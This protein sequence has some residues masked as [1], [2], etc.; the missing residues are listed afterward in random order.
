[1]GLF[2]IKNE[3]FEDKSV[4][5]ETYV[6]D[7]LP[8]REE[9]MY[10]YRF[11]LEDI[12]TG[13]EPNNILVYGETGVGKTVATRRILDA[14]SDAVEDQDDVSFE[15][16]WVNCKDKTSYQATV[17]TVNEL[18]DFEDRIKGTGYSRSDVLNMLWRE[19][20]ALEA[21]H[22]MI[23]L[24]EVDS[25]G[26]DDSLLYQIPRAKA[27]GHVDTMIGVI[28]IS[29]NF[30][31]RENIS[32][33]ASSTLKED[34]I[35]FSTYDAPQLQEILLQRSELAFKDGVLDEGIVEYVAAIVAQDTGSARDAIEILRLAGRLA[36]KHEDATVT[37]DHVREASEQLERVIVEKELYSLPT[38]YHVLL[39]SIALLEKKG[40]LPAR[41]KAVYNVYE[42]V[43]N[44][45]QISPKAQRTIHDKLSQLALKGFLSITEKNK[46]ESGGKYWEYDLEIN[47]D[48]VNEVLD[49]VDRLSDIREETTLSQ[50]S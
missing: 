36:R 44:D 28:G 41:R 14:L 26:T 4:L 40:K 17:D 48:T 45:I 19:I 24:D 33:R 12:K 20:D 39:Q 8:G 2:D 5:R 23:V 6:P 31:F 34:E 43:C 10:D 1:M 13:D 29:N 21:T 49:D 25:L 46:G 27:N 22:V 30:T 15:H 42:Q 32:A 7:E 16:V 38:Q 37:E 35:H 47:P 18:L 50:F 9:E 11:A 3:I